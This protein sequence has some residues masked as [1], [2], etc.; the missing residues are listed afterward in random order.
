MAQPCTSWITGDDVAACCNEES[1]SSVVFDVVAAEASALLFQLSGR[2]FSGECGPKTVRPR[3][4]SCYCGYQVLSRGHI[5]GPWDWG[6]W[7]Y[8]S[9]CDSCL[10]ACN[11]SRVKL[12]GYPVREITEILID[13]DVVAPSEYTIWKNRYVTRLDN[14][15]WPRQQNLTLPDTDDHTFAISYTYGAD[16][17]ELGISAAAQLGC[18]LY[19]QCNG[20][21]CALPAGT[22]RIQRQG[23]T[24]DKLAFTSWSW[25]RDRGWQTGMALVDAFLSAYNPA[26]IKR[27]PVFYSPGKHQYAQEW[28]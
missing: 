28:G 12:S 9:F 20:Q 3:C 10:V 13:G 18:E 4:D 5:V 2:I 6:A 15:H 17:P 19:K 23:I 11:P 14:G 22:T 16:P 25:R 26:G 7:P 24:V 1:S 21:T 8:W 27:R